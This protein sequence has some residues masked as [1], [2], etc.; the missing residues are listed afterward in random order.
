MVAPAERADLPIGAFACLAQ[1]RVVLPAMVPPLADRDTVLARREAPLLRVATGR[2]T[3]GHAPVDAGERVADALRC[4][5]VKT[6]RRLRGDDS[7]ADVDPDG[8]RHDG[9]VGREHASDRHAVA[10]VRV[11]HHGHAD[12]H[13]ERADVAHLLERLGLDRV[14]G[15][16]A[17][18]LG[19][20]AGPVEPDGSTGRDAHAA[21]PPASST[22]SMRRPVSVMN[23]SSS[24]PPPWRAASSAGVPSATRRP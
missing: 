3:D 11:G 15:Q 1:D 13:V 16:P 17:P 4:D 12:C 18:G 24:V 2:L 7:A 9:T 6:E 8:V 19:P 22:S 21:G 23:T 14:H 10:L 5:L 20:A